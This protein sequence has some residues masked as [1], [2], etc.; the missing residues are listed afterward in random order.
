[1]TVSEI[2]NLYQ[3]ILGRIS[4]NRLYEAFSDVTY[5]T[6]QNGFGAIY[7]QLRELE[8]NYRYLVQ[9]RL[10]GYQDKER[11]KVLRDLKCR[12]MKLADLAWREWQSAFSPQWYYSQK[13]YR[14]INGQ[15]GRG[16]EPLW[17][18]LA[19]SLD[20]ERMLGRTAGKPG[21]AERQESLRRQRE[22]LSG[23][24]FLELLF[25]DPWREED[26]TQV[27]EHYAA[28]EEST[29]ALCVSALLLACQ[30]LFD[31][32]KLLLLAELCDSASP[33]VSM[34]ALTALMLLIEVHQV[35]IAW[36]PHLT[37]RISLLFDRP[38]I[39]TAAQGIFVQ[40]IRAKE[41]EQV[42]RRMQEEFLPEMNKLSSSIRQK[43]DENKEQS[44]EELKNDL[45][46]LFEDGSM[47]EKMMEFSKMQT[48]GEDVYLSTFSSLK[49]YPFFKEIYNWFLPFE[50]QHTVIAAIFRGQQAHRGLDLPKV[51]TRTDFLCDSDKYSFCL[52]LAQVPEQY[53]DQMS[54]NMGADS[55]AFQEMM[56]ME[57]NGSRR[58]KAE[59]LTNLYIQ[60]LYRF[61]RL[62]PSK[63]D[64]EDVFSLPLD[65]YANPLTADY[66]TSE[67]CQGRVAAMYLK[68][69]H[70]AKAVVL[71]RQLV[72]LHPADFDLLRRTA[73]CYQQ[74]QDYESAVMYYERADLVRSDNLWVIRRLAAC[75]RQ[76]GRNEQ[77][78]EYYRKAAVLSPDN[79]SLCLNQ[80]H[81]LTDLKRYSD[82]L[83]CYY[84]AEFL[85]AGSP[86]IWRP[87][88]WC[89]LLT[90]RYGQAEKYYGYLLS[91]SS[92]TIED[93]M[94]A[95]HLNWLQG[96]LHHAVELYAEGIRRT[97]T[98]MTEFVVLLEQDLPLLVQL[99]ADKQDAPFVFDGVRFEMEK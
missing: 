52:N 74:I 41:A 6:Q 55:E 5:L 89:L 32:Y 61:Y 11:D 75:L 58:L 68:K 93:F 29:Q 51:L 44:Q 66:F 95:G 25:S 18:G 86:R 59:T 77:A 19:R 57:Q 43:L 45:Q 7:D 91:E 34:R 92:P 69:N 26:Y 90:G 17:A 47:S 40:L 96:R 64:F 71:Y 84:K 28:L 20:D 38:E 67:E 97:N 80:G 98:L 30:Q 24:L 21:V 22:Q 76:T 62:F 50:A 4:Q 49:F 13:R 94:N 46:E 73:W 82:A 65:F 48:E 23:E 60:D 70:I 87:I 3:R 99:G 8:T 63:Q 79:L 39:R 81:C 31:E 35:R 83:N 27:S 36:Y 54:A 1:M 53:R 33:L 72:D 56:Q 37:S 9:Y 85:F 14:D 15:G 2:K 42:S 12:L 88:A 78:L 10:D 16:L